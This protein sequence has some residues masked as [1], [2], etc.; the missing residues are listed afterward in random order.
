MLEVKK[1]KELLKIQNTMYLGFTAWQFLWMLFGIILGSILFYILPFHEMVKA[2]LL[3]VVIFFFG[4][5]GFLKPFGLNMF[6]FIGCLIESHRLNRHPLVPGNGK[7]E[8][9]VIRKNKV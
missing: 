9:N 2:T 4:S 8:L 5:V 3:V 7:E 6:K 1:N